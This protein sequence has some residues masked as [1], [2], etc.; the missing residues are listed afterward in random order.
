MAGNNWNSRKWLE[1]TV[2]GWKWTE[3]AGNELNGQKW[4]ELAANGLN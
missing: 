2:N 3:V 1:I 4:L